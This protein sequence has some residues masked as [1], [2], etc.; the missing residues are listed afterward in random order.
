VLAAA[1]AA[2]G[3]EPPPG[4]KPEPAS[5]LTGE[6][7]AGAGFGEK[8]STHVDPKIDFADVRKMATP[9]TAGAKGISVRWKGQFKST[10]DGFYTFTIVSEGCVRLWVDDVML[11]DNWKNH[12]PTENSGKIRLRADRWYDIQLDYAKPDPRRRGLVRLACSAKGIPKAVIPSGLL[13]PARGIRDPYPEPYKG[14]PGFIAKFDG[15]CWGRQRHVAKKRME[16]SFEPTFYTLCDLSGYSKP[17]PRST[18]LV[19]A[20]LG[21]ERQGEYREALEIYQKVIEEHG[22][23]LY[24]IS[25]YGIYVP[26]GQYCQRRILRFPGKD[27]AFYRTKHDSR[28]RKEYEQARRKNSLEGLA[29][30]VDTM[31]ATSVGGKAVLALGDAAL[32]RGHYLEALEYYLTVRDIFPDRELHTQE[33]ALKIALCRKMLGDRPPQVKAGAGAA[34]GLG[35]AELALLKRTVEKSKYRPAPRL[36][37]SASAPHE[38]ADDYRFFPPTEDPLALESPVWRFSLPGNRRAFFSYVQPVATGN[39]VLYRHKNVV[40]SRSILTGELRWKNDTG[41]RVTWQNG[42]ERQYPMEDVLVQD[43]LVFTPMY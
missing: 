32:D 27:R 42:R 39:S 5:G 34:S 18:A 38:A 9:R 40:C 29:H 11:V 21:K 26:V 16:L 7:Y 14:P 6:Y 28:A 30:I 33:L 17:E 12:R 3:A 37:Q 4:K 8:K 25:R 19:R 20:A 10:V 13:R 35:D 36:L 22:D 31:L 2:A 1:L 41:G 23:D 24:R 15:I 43:G